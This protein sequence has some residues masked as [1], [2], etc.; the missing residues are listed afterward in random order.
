MSSFAFSEALR[1]TSS[2]AVIAERYYFPI[3]SLLI[4]ARRSGG[5]LGPKH[6]GKR[7]VASFASGDVFPPPP[8]DA[9]RSVTKEFE[10][11]THFLL[12]LVAAVLVNSVALAEK[13][14]LSG[15]ELEKQADAIV[16]ATIDHIR[17][18]AEP[19][20]I[21]RARGNSD[22][23]IYLTLRLETIEKGDVSG[24]Q[25]EARCF[26]IRYRRTSWEYISPSGH[27]PIPA[28]GTRVRVYLEKEDSLW[29]V[30][31]PNGIMPLDGNAQDA[32]EVTQLRSRAFTYFLPIEEWWLLIIVSVPALA[33]LTLIVRCYRRRQLQKR[34]P[35]VTEIG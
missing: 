25:V 7:N 35:R 9:H 15:G 22:W 14:P 2:P 21:E 6:A 12:S 18:E 17:V 8:P 27:R 19:S 23:G 4:R 5:L 3:G 13:F 34:K 10:M 11:K 1:Q 30:V 33:C 26:R 29:G 24:T 20:Q 28:T 16:V 32:S 31:L